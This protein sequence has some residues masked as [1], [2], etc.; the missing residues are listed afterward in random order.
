MKRHITKVLMVNKFLYPRGGAETYFLKVGEYLQQQGIQVEYFGMYDEKNTVGNNAGQYTANMDF[1]TAG[2]QRL[3]YPFKIIY[4]FEAAAKI[5]KVIRDFKPDIIH[6]NNI[7]FQLTPSI[8]EAACKEKVPVVQTVHDYQMLCPNHLFFD[9]NGDICEKCLHGSP[10]NCAKGSCIH[11]SKIK[12]IMGSLEALLYRGRRTYEKV[13]GY[14]C[15]S[16]FLESKLNEVELYRG[17]TT[18]I[19]NFI[20]MEALS[21]EITKEDYVLFFGR[22]SQEKG[23]AMFLEA[24]K[25]MPH[26]PFVIAGSGPMEEC[27]RGIDNVRYVG[28]KTGQ[29]LKQLIARAKFSVYPSIWYENCPLS[30]LESISLG[31]PVVASSLGGIP[32]LISDGETGLLIKNLST[33]ALSEAIMKLYDD[34]ARLSHMYEFCIQKRSEFITLADYGDRLLSYYEHDMNVTE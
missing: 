20:E 24:C 28:F 21:E 29:E 13:E 12:S 17:K 33:K 34:S 27:C 10:W 11:G 7:N 9:N 19:H 15:P 22:L 30:V 25:T 26:I 32:E 2:L 16:H 14:I 18:T 1:H 8:I 5:R 4:S 6:L 31:T 3:I 23:L